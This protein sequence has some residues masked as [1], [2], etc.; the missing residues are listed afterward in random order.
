MR[1]PLDDAR[2]KTHAFFDGRR[3]RVEWPAGAIADAPQPVVKLVLNLVLLG[4][5]A[6]P[7][8]GTVTVALSE[9]QLGV[10]AA[11]SGAALTDEK[12]SALSGTPAALNARLVQPYYAGAL[13][14]SLQTKVAFE[15]MP[16]RLAMSVVLAR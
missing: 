6:L 4:S 14:R 16:D 1:Q 10:I 9:R 12:K 3:V 11:G 5:E 2:A 7:R 15:E 13:A 8:G